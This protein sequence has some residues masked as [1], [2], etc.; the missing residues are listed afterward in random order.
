[1]CGGSRAAG[2]DLIDEV[3]ENLDASVLED[4]TATPVRSDMRV[5]HVCEGCC[6]GQLGVPQMRVL[7]TDCSGLTESESRK[8]DANTLAE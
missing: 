5:R 4:G 3:F 8:V 1:M 7:P 6:P 2:G